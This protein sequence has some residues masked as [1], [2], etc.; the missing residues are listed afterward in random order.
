[1]RID[2]NVVRFLLGR[3]F[4]EVEG[5]VPL[6]GPYVDYPL[7]YDT[8]ADMRGHVVLVPEGVVPAVPATTKNVVFVCMDDAAAQAVTDA[9]V[10]M[11]LVRDAESLQHLYN[12]MLATFVRNEQLDTQLRTYVDTFAGF[13][14]MLDACAQA[15]GCSCA[16]VDTRYQLAFRADT[17]LEDGGLLDALPEDFPDEDFVNLFMASSEY[18]RLR[19][20]RSVF[21]FP[22]S[23][24]VFLKN[25]FSGNHVVGM[26]A[27]QH[28]GDA[29]SARYVHFL[30]DYLT[31]FVEEMYA[32]IGSFGTASIEA[33]QIREALVSAF[34]GKPVDAATLDRMLAREHGGQQ[35]H[36]V[37]LCFERSFTHETSGELDYLV[38]R[39]E[40]RWPNAYCAHI[41]DGLFAFMDLGT[42]THEERLAFL[43]EVAVFARETLVKVGVSRVFASCVHVLAARMQARAALDQGEA[44]APMRWVH[45]F[46]GNALDWLLAHGLGNYPAEYV[47]HPAVS[48]L[49]RY[50]EANGTDLVHTLR[51]FMECR[52]NATEA[53]ERL[54]VAR[55]TLL[56]RL[57]RI[58]E[59]APVNLDDF[60]ERLYLGMSLKLHAL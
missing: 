12:Y 51:V 10:P 20:G 60:D 33:R 46:T 16:L 50:D 32:R 1:M 55:S 17:E 29:L 9:R 13:Q 44:T 14:P 45:R 23:G 53:S 36:Y 42:A 56:N 27:I 3:E 19:E 38:R 28:G 31:E 11:V 54:F 25:V 34:E 47:A 15:M 6:R 52:Y 7:L 35:G 18:R 21:A 59:I 37:V 49:I 48:E 41:D 5:K 57:K 30:L 40:M 22:G 43:Q 2:G 26:L 58:D 4:D 24:N 39:I 8:R